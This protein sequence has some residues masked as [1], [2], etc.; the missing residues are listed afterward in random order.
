MAR[1]VLPAGFGVLAVITDLADWSIDRFGEIQPAA[2]GRPERRRAAGIVHRE[3][4]LAS[5]LV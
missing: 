1:C 5:G 2:V 3:R 4:G